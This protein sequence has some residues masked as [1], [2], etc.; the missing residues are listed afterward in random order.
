MSVSATGPRS[1]PVL[2]EVGGG[3]GD[4]DDG[5]GVAAAG[6][7]ADGV[8]AQVGASAADVLSGADDVAGDGVVV[9][10]VSS[11]DG[12]V[13]VVVGSVLGV[14]CAGDGV[15]V[16]D[17]SSGDGVVGMVVVSALGDE[18]GS[19]ASTEAGAVD[20]SIGVGLGGPRAN[21]VTNCTRS[22]QCGDGT[23]ARV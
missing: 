12:D 6:D 23:D 1:G 20:S 17:M 8:D 2:D 10:V 9:V 13:G 15:G 11:V 22:K 14:G 19:G 7:D 4:G 21:K 18:D 16:V 3:A 5:D